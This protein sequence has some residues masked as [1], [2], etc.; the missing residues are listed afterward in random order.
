MQRFLREK[1]YNLPAVARAPPEFQHAEGSGDTETPD[2]N[3][4]SDTD[5]DALNMRRRRPPKVV[6]E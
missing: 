6:V 4:L 1:W 5:L 3:W 2:Y